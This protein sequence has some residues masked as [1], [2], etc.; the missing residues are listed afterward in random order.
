M[1]RWTDGPVDRW[2]D[3]PMDR[4][5]DG[6]IDRWTD[7]PMDRWTDG[8]RD[9]WTG[10]A[11]R[12][13]FG[14]PF[15]VPVLRAAGRRPASESIGP[16]VLLSGLAQQLAPRQRCPDETISPITPTRR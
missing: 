11:H 4:L 7:G 14:V 2:T 16:S 6:P 3:G 1:D 12:S 8:P 5:T 9:R 15:A 10:R 13:E